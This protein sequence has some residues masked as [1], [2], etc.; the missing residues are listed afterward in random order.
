MVKIVSVSILVL[1]FW[2]VSP[3]I[4]KTYVFSFLGI[5]TS[6]ISGLY[7][8]VAALFSALAFAA[9][10]VTV[11]YQK[12]QL[13]VQKRELALAKEENEK[14]TQ[15]AAYTALLTYYA[16]NSYNPIA[17]ELTPMDIAKKLNKLL[18]NPDRLEDEKNT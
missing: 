13:D 2:L 1:S 7:T 15:I 14:N 16:G 6:D 4:L 18:N 10:L 3:V 11:W 5:N 8:A 9:L 12:Q 17:C